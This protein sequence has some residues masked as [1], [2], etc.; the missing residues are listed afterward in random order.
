VRGR[1]RLWRRTMR[2]CFDVGTRLCRAGAPTGLFKVSP[3]AGRAHN[4][5]QETK[6][7]RMRPRGTRSIASAASRP[8]AAE[9]VRPAR[10]KAALRSV[11]QWSQEDPATKE[12]DMAKRI[13]N[14]L[15]GSMNS[16]RFNLMHCA[17]RRLERAGLNPHE[18]F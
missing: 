8:W 10:A 5:R 18:P 9:D 13:L 14:R 17:C 4:V 16:V 11:A 2:P 15:R 6:P 3:A 7:E 1:M 12:T